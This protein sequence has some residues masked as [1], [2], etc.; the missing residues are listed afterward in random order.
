MQLREEI[1]VNSGAL[2]CPINDYFCKFF[3]NGSC[4]LINAHEKCLVLKEHVK[5]N[6]KILE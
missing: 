3:E 1:K 6:K 4:K 5:K 2:E